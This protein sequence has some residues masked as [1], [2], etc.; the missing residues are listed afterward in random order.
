MPSWPHTAKHAKLHGEERE[1]YLM[2]SQYTRTILSLALLAFISASRQTPSKI[3]FADA[4][5]KAGLKLE[6]ITAPDKRYLIETMGGGVTL[7]DYDNDGW[8]DVYLTNTPTV[9][10]FKANRLPANR[11]YRNNHDGSFSDVSE[12]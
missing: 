1:P 12:K 4:T 11:F 9:E 5:A 3:Y 10:S 8:L 2:S 7:F 6:R